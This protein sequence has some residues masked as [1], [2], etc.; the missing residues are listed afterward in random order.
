MAA[1]APRFAINFLRF[2]MQPP[3]GTGVIE[4]S[5]ERRDMS[6]PREFTRF[7]EL[8]ME[9]ARD[10]ANRHQAELVH[11]AETWRRLAE[12]AERFDRL[13]ADLDKAFD[14]PSP[15]DAEFRPHR[16]SH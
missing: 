6:N 11:M 12:D 16:R 8:C 13:V 9:L 5:P 1:P 4:G 2:C 15:R 14:P 3:V 10:P 7:A